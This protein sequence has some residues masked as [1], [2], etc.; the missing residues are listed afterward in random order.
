MQQAQQRIQDVT[1]HAL[2]GRRGRRL[3]EANLGQLEIP[4]ADLVP[5]E[6]VED[7]GDAARI[8]T[9][10]IARRPR[11]SPDCSRDRIQASGPVRSA[12]SVAVD[13][14][15]PLIN[16]NRV[17]FHSLVQKL[18]APTT[19][20]S[21]VAWSAPGLAPCA[22]EKPQRV[23]AVGIHPQQRVDDVAAGLGHLLARR[24][25]HQAGQH[26]RAERDRC[27]PWR[28]A[29]TASCARPRRRG[30]RSR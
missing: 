14:V 9:A 29:R 23:C 30:C 21:L 24:V 19:H 1:K 28:T 26:H 22:S 13:P 12:G 17:A 2:R 20:S 27:R 25:T 10:R 11:R 15:A 6:V 8:H 3:G 4:V 18:R 16:A 5:G 7:V